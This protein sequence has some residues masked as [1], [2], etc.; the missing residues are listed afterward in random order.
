VSFFVVG[1][2]FPF[3]GSTIVNATTSYLLEPR[4]IQ[5]SDSGASGNATITTGVG[6]GT[7]ATYKVSIANINSFQSLV[8]NFCDNSPIVGDTCLNTTGYPGET[9][10][11]NMSVSGA[12]V[13]AIS[14]TC[15][16]GNEVGGTGWS[17]TEPNAYTVELTSDGSHSICSGSVGT[18]QTQVFSISGITNPDVIESFYGRLYT[19]AA[20]SPTGYTSPIGSGVGTYLD[21]GGIALSTTQVIT[22][23]AKVEEILEFCVSGDAQNVTVNP[24]AGNPWSPGDCSSTQASI[25]PAVSLGTTVGSN[26]ILTPEHVWTGE[27]YFQ[28]S[29]NA[30]NGAVL[31][32]HSSNTCGGLSANGGT[33]SCPIQAAG[34]YSGNSGQTSAYNFTTAANNDIALF[35]MQ[36]GTSSDGSVGSANGI[37]SLTNLAPYNGSSSNYGLD[38]A[39]TTGVTGAYG[40]EIAS[41]N[42]SCY[43]VN[44]SV[45]FAA[46]SSLA[47]P[48][49]IYSTNISLIATGNF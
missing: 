23:T 31:Y 9:S 35:G 27:D 16:S 8:I 49:G 24:A 33:D 6:S 10:P 22:I 39:A 46:T 3:L 4:S 43:L 20:T 13:A 40:N 44:D 37:G 41:T 38:D 18:P 1:P 2:Y 42:S 12:T 11:G 19:Y 14:T 47:T 34:D 48:A 17:V 15:G 28:L 32:M 45:L 36:L 26:V 29:T 21:Y 5:M 30:T 7:N 25:S